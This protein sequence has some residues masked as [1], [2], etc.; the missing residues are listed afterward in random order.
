MSQRANRSVFSVILIFLVI[1]VAA[2]AEVKLPGI[3]TSHMVLQRDKPIAIWGW[4]E[5]DEQVKVSLGSESTEVK[6]TA[7]GAW[8]VQFKARPAS[9]TPIKLVVKGKG[10]QL[11]VDDILVGDVWVGSGQSNMRRDLNGTMHREE[12]IA[13]AKYPQIRVYHVPKTEVESPA[14]DINANWLTCSPSAVRY[15]SA[16]LFHFGERIH[17]ETSIPIGLI[18]SSRSGSPIEPW[19][20]TEERSGKLY[21][22]MIAPLR[23]FPV[24]GCLW[25]QGETNCM[26]SNGDGFKYFDKQKTLIKGWRQFWGADMPFYFVQLAPWS[27]PK[28]F[29]G[30]LPA[31]WEAQVATLKLPKT[32]MV[33]TTD[34]VDV[35]KDIHPKNKRDVGYRLALW[36]LAKDYGKDV[37]YSGPLFKGL[38]IEGNKARVSFAHAAGL[39]SRD[40]KALS[41]FKVAGADGKFVSAQAE[42]DGDTVV[43]SADG[44][45]PVQVQFGWHKVANPNLVN[46]AGLPASPFQSKD[47]QGGTGE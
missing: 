26:Y 15:F 24:K 22:G 43:V 21:N 41:E 42:I 11:V 18:S 37:V 14:T 28:Y 8:R 44:V 47:W 6:A 19:T 45:T 36:A 33:V 40:G 17:K 35:I 25:Y 3:F 2:S 20:V 31:F 16:V 29:P 12:S 30:K 23:D 9:A 7:A 5:A 1:T 39:K 38:Q 46:G 4:A 32:G 13:G 27:R 10:E 34:L